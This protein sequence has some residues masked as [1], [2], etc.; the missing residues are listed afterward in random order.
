MIDP[1]LGSRRLVMALKRDWGVIVNRKPRQRLQ[2]EISHEAIWCRT[3][4]LAQVSKPHPRPSRP[5]TCSNAWLRR[6]HQYRRL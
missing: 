1:R 4:N 3:R 2:L 6:G 5:A